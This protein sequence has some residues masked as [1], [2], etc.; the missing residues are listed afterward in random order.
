MARASERLSS[1][2][3]AASSK[4]TWVRAL[5]LGVWVP[6]LLDLHTGMEG[7]KTGTLRNFLL[8]LE[9]LERPPCGVSC[10]EFVEVEGTGVEGT[11]LRGRGGFWARSSSAFLFQTV[12]NTVQTK[13]NPN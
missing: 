5:I 4:K 7:A 6:I 1:E 13:H 9:Y 8:P 12:P 2:D 11:D 10:R 3:E